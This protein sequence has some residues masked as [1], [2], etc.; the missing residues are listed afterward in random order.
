MAGAPPPNVQQP[1]STNGQQPPP[2]GT[3]STNDGTAADDS[4]ANW[5]APPEFVNEALANDQGFHTI[6]DKPFFPLGGTEAL[7]GDEIVCVDMTCCLPID[8]HG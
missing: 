1:P 2:K 3:K 7:A 8:H 4:F 6:G 5:L